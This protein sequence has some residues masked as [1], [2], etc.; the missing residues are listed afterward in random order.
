MV[1]RWGDRLI[2]TD[3]N[4]YHLV[5]HKSCRRQHMSPQAA[6]VEVVGVV[7]M[8]P[9]YKHLL[10]S[11]VPYHCNSRKNQNI[12]WIRPHKHDLYMHRNPSH[13][14]LPRRLPMKPPLPLSP[15]PP[16]LLC[17]AT[18]PTSHRREVGEPDWGVGVMVEA[19]SKKAGTAY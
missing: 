8:L 16:M 7:E 11:N 14:K 12:V 9:F 4:M 19:G 15:L 13:Y 6:G 18:S 2:H 5:D 1:G 17:S 10:C 3:R